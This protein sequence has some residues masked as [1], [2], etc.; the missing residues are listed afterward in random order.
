MT[1]PRRA[2]RCW[3]TTGSRSASIPPARP[4][5]AGCKSTTSAACMAEGSS[6]S[7]RTPPTPAAAGPRSRPDSGPAVSRRRGEQL[8]VEVAVSA[9]GALPGEVLAHTALLE[10]S[11]RRRVTPGVE[12][13][14]E[15]LAERRGAEGAELESGAGPRVG[16][17]LPDRV[18]E[19]AGRVDDRQ[20]AVAQAVEL[21]QAT[22]LVARR[23]QEDVCSRHDPVGE[24]LVEAEAHGDAT[25]EG[26][27][28]GVEAGLEGRDA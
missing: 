23:H 25:W 20:G 28:E 14:I 2:T 24:R 15:R 10:P 13:V 6:S 26:L 12:R 3:T 27:G 5:S 8:G 4:I 18:V 1:R 19:A 22:R 21:A 11:P 16:V 7:T 17:E 9:R